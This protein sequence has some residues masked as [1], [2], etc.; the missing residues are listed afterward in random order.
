M[1]LQSYITIRQRIRH[2]ILVFPED[3]ST[4]WN[5]SKVMTT[6]RVDHSIIPL[7]AAH[8]RKR[9]DN[10]YDCCIA[11]KNVTIKRHRKGK[12]SEQR[13]QCSRCSMVTV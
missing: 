1:L 12:Q 7:P 9:V 10:S 3:E 2:E 6:L 5:Y 4:L 11:F 8:G 13:R